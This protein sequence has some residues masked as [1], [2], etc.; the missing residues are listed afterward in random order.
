MILKKNSYYSGNIDNIKA[1][2]QIYN[3]GFT[4]EQSLK[5]LGTFNDL[6]IKPVFKKEYLDSNLN[7]YI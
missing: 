6:K 3:T 1:Y 4:L 7:I 2:K 5:S